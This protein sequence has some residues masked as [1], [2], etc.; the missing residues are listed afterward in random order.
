MGQVFQSY[1]EL[2]QIKLDAPAM[3]PKLNL[4]A[5]CSLVLGGR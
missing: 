1:P 4:G 3:P 5:A 2:F